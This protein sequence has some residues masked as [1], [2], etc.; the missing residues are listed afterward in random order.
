MLESTFTSNKYSFI[1]GAQ[2]DKIVF[3]DKTAHIV[4]RVHD[5]KTSEF[6]GIFIISDL[7][8]EKRVTENDWFLGISALKVYQTVSFDIKAF[9]CAQ[10]EHT[11]VYGIM[12]CDNLDE[13]M[14][15]A[16]QYERILKND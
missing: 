3:I 11:K 5:I 4:C 6:M 9:E 7:V 16:R 1:S 15:F 8:V 12:V 13:A 14:L 2:I 10:Y